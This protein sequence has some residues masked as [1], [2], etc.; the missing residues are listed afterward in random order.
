MSNEDYL[1]FVCLPFSGRCLPFSGRWLSLSS[2]IGCIVIVYYI[3]YIIGPHTTV[4]SHTALTA[5]NLTAAWIEPGTTGK[6][7]ES[8]SPMPR[9][10]TLSVD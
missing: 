10:L 9:I 2:L 1:L 5:A 6:E 3:L 8:T 4:K 7:I